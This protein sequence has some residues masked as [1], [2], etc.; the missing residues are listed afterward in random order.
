M[1]TRLEAQWSQSGRG[2]TLRLER[3]EEYDQE[4]GS[5]YAP[6]VFQT[7]AIDSCRTDLPGDTWIKQA[8]E[9]LVKGETLQPR[10]GNIP[11]LVEASS[12]ALFSESVLLSYL[13]AS[14]DELVF[15]GLLDDIFDNDKMTVGAKL[16]AIFSHRALG[17]VENKRNLSPEYLDQVAEYARHHR[18]PLQF[19]LPAFPFKDQNPFRTEAPANH[20]DIGEGALLVRLHCL[21][22]A[23]NQIHPYDAHWIVVADG[24]TYASIFDVERRQAEL[25]LANVRELR[26]RLNLGNSVQLI[27]LEELIDRDV[28]LD[29]QRSRGRSSGFR[30]VQEHVHERLGEL[31]KSDSVV[32]KSMTVLGRGI[33]WN[34][35]LRRYVAA[36]ER[37]TIWLALCRSRSREQDRFHELHDEVTERARAAALDYAAF[38]LTTGWTNLI[39][40]FFPAALRATVHAKQS[41]IAIPR[42]GKVF[43]WNGVGTLEALPVTSSS[44]GTRTLIEVARKRW[45][46]KCL[47]GSNSPFA[48]VPG[49]LAV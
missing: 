30:R 2:V 15:G 26:D 13:K 14:E 38:N 23:V 1:E 49:E 6:A 5:F 4:T 40:R 7:V 35:N 20:V 10:Y 41:Q 9:R 19:L 44:I 34:L 32:R 42:L 25:Y 8:L 12:G 17:N 3:G 46:P 16:H 31:I 18:L 22:L 11:P 48:Y 27:H 47:P 29:Q 45:R 39:G 24:T 21:A 33:K 36:E 28:P 37:E 43:P